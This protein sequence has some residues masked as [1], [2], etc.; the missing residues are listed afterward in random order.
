MV[1]TAAVRS[2][3]MASKADSESRIGRTTP[4]QNDNSSSIHDEVNDD[5]EMED[6][7]L[8]AEYGGFV[9]FLQNLNPRE[10]EQLSNTH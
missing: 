10:L 1:S 7:R 9:S 8:L 2:T 6:R 3:M 5:D 4:D